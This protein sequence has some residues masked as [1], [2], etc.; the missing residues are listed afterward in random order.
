MRQIMGF[1]LNAF[2]GRISDM[3]TWKDKLTSAVVCGLSGELGLVPATQK[4]FGE[5]R[6]RLGEE[7]A[8]R[9]DVATGLNLYPLA[10][11]KEGARRWGAEASV[12]TTV[13]FISIG[14]FGDWG[15]DEA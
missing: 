8:H 5:L 12:G 2:L 9:M 10:S 14:E 13:A 15:Y 11:H 3:R 6:A 1:D 4:L 7:E